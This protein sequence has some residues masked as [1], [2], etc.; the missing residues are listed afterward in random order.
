MATNK[1]PQIQGSPDF[2]TELPEDP[3]ERQL[4]KDQQYEQQQQQNKWDILESI[5]D[6][7]DDD[8][9]QILHT[10]SGLLH[11]PQ[12]QLFYHTVFTTRKGK[13]TPMVLTSDRQFH[14]VSYLP[15]RLIDESHPECLKNEDGTPRYKKISEVPQDLRYYFFDY[16]GTRYR[17]NKP[18]KWTDAS[19]KTI[20]N[21]G[22]TNAIDK[23]IPTKKIFTYVTDTISEYFYHYAPSEYDVMASAITFTYIKHLLGNS[24]YTV[25]FGVKDTGKSHALCLMHYLSF[26]GYFAG[27]GTVA[28]SCRKV[29]THD[30]DW[31]Q[32]EFEKMCD[33]ERTMFTAISNNGFTPGGRYTL[34]DTNVKDLWD[35]CLSLDVYGA[36]GLTCNSLDKLH[37]S[38]INRF[39]VITSIRNNKHVKNIFRLSQEELNQDLYQHRIL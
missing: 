20:D 11:T 24:V 21:D 29:H 37:D 35:Q 32:D 7:P 28:G 26:R 10:Y 38:L 31:Y 25:F 18:T 39:Y 22:I 13:Y 8:Q 30:V 5:M 9:H 6:N 19:I 34:T 4:L 16:N 2:S 15:N 3:I 12:K 1:T 27:K 17:F 33:N 23:Q 36:K 14:L